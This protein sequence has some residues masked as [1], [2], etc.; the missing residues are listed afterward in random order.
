MEAARTVGVMAVVVISAK[1]LHRHQAARVDTPPAS[2]TCSTAA[3]V[4]DVSVQPYAL[5]VSAWLRWDAVERRLPLDPR[6]SVLEVG[7][8]LGGLS[9]LLAERFPYAAVETDATAARSA[10]ER[11]RPYGGT[12]LCGDTSALE[13][14]FHADM[15]CAFEVLEHIEDDRAAVRDWSAHVTPGGRMIVTTP[16]YP[17]RFGPADARV[18]HWR[19][20]DAATLAALLRDAGLDDIDVRHYGGPVSFALDATRQRLAKLD[21]RHTPS[22]RMTATASS[23]QLLQ[24]RGGLSARMT[25][26]VSYPAVLMARAFPDQGAGLIAVGRRPG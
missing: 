18:G 23:G 21:S 26:I 9:Q 12:V 22:D 6:S 7:C 4:S 16:G 11:V 2:S 24:P 15:V 8:G 14:G 17:D 5:T 1:Y 20:Y 19:R 3:I 10:H 25:R 13:P